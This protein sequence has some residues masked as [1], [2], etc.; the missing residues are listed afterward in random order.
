MGINEFYIF[1]SKSSYSSLSE[2]FSDNDIDPENNDD[3][4]KAEKMKKKK[5][6]ICYIY[7]S[8]IWFIINNNTT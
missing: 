2:N 6:C 3:A 5:N 4:H 1:N 8:F 7:S